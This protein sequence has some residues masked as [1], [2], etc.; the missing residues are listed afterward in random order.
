MKRLSLILGCLML[1]VPAFCGTHVQQGDFITI[2]SLTLTNSNGIKFADGTSQTT[3]GGGGGG[4]SS[5][6]A[7]GKGSSVD[8]TSISSPTSQINFSS[9][10]FRVTLISPTTAFIDIDYSSMTVGVVIS[11]KGFIA[12]SSTFTVFD[13]SG[14]SMAIKDGAFNLVFDTAPTVGQKLSILSVS[15]ANIHIGGGGD[16][17]GTGGG[18]G[19]GGS[20]LAVG[21]GTLSGVTTISS[22]TMYISLDPLKFTAELRGGGTAFISLNGVSYSTQASGPIHSWRMDEG[23]GRRFIDSVSRNDISTFTAT[24]TWI[25]NPLSTTT[26]PAFDGTVSAQAENFTSFAPSCSQPFSFSIWASF[27]AAGTQ[28]FLISQYDGAK[29][30]YFTKNATSGLRDEEMTFTL[31][32]SNGNNA[33]TTFAFAPK[34][35][36][37]GRYPMYHFVGTMDGSHT[38]AGISLYVNGA[39]KAIDTIT[40]DNVTGGFSCQPST[41]IHIASYNFNAGGLQHNGQLA[42][43]RVWNRVLSQTEI[44]AL[45]N[46][47]PTAVDPIQQ[48][49]LPEQTVY[50]SKIPGV[51]LDCNL[52]SG[53]T[54]SG[55]TCTDN[56]VAIN[57]ILNTATST[58]PVKLVIDGATATSGII[59]PRE[60]HVTIE[61]LGWDTGFFVKSGANSACI[62]NGFVSYPLPTADTKTG[63]NITLSNFKCHGN[64]GTF[65]N[66]NSNNGDARGSALNYYSG[67]SIFGVSNVT[68]DHIWMYDA[69]TYGVNVGNIGIVNLTNSRVDSP[70]SAGVSN[71]DG[72]HVNGPADNVFISDTYFH[73]A[74]DAI[75]F[76]APES[77]GGTINN[78]TINNIVADQCASIIRSYQYL[79]APLTGNYGVN[80]MVVNNLVGSVTGLF[81]PFQLY[82]PD[83]PPGTPADLS[84]SLK[85]SNVTVTGSQSGAAFIDMNGEWG[86]VSFD[87][88]S[89]LAPQG[90]DQFLKLRPTSTFASVSLS[91]CKI[92]RNT[93]G[94]AAA[95]ALQVQNG[96]TVKR[97]M[98]DNFAIEDMVG[99]TYGPIGSLIDINAGGSV[100]NFFLKS[101]NMANITSM[102]SAGSQA[103]VTTIAP[104]IWISSSMF[105]ANVDISSGL[106]INKSAGT[107]GQVLISNGAG[108][109]PAWKSI[110]TSTVNAAVT[111]TDCTS[112]YYST[113]TMAANVTQTFLATTIGASAICGAAVGPLEITNT[114]T[115]GPRLK[116]LGSLPTSFTFDNPDAINAQGAW[117]IIYYKP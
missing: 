9:G 60:G 40:I 104:Q 8:F 98:M 16:A 11:S 69:P 97:L 46:S 112:I 50:A 75:A 66:G 88:V 20:P 108:T 5:S 35:T 99:Q 114:T 13:L 68:M 96:V 59:I 64:R 6:L 31:A 47:G 34:A 62:S 103:G 15:G 18:G 82:S 39:R 52:V 84:N 100:G 25:K 17:V 36:V 53:K 71:T 117:L 77:Y 44:T 38:G 48:P 29:G 2:S 43:A 92:Y 26:I 86:E 83:Q 54:A 89:W 33:Q 102:F 14:G 27:D 105:N 42:G 70:Q 72:I 81:F 87:H 78:V 63:G 74:D 30:W 51:T 95:Y 79:I 32:D 61:G 85:M 37:A 80:S 24:P 22:P 116:S 10:P 23:N 19:G 76:N 7:V 110:I 3:A 4:G 56:T 67:I 94:N 12:P 1:A 21:T 91:D 57:R 65:P 107:V 28:D 101:Q 113:M 109:I 93:G 41:P 73:T 49:V 45:Y 90:A 111:A 58:S 55:G 106:K 115:A